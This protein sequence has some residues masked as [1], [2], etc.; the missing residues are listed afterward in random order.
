MFCE[1]RSNSDSGVPRSRNICGGSDIFV[2]EITNPV[3][4]GES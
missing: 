4:S 1:V 3:I 2:P